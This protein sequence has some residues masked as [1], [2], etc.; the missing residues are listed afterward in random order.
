VWWWS[1]KAWDKIW[2]L[3]LYTC[4]LWYRDVRIEAAQHQYGS[5]LQL[6]K[7]GEF[8]CGKNVSGQFAN[9]GLGFLPYCSCW[10]NSKAG[11]E[12]MKAGTYFGVQTRKPLSLSAR[13][14]AVIVQRLQERENGEGRIRAMWFWLAKRPMPKASKHWYILEERIDECARM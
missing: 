3:V 8:P 10:T 7:L 5:A 11:E 2:D 12:N 4:C 13:I 6:A 9:L 14:S 1:N